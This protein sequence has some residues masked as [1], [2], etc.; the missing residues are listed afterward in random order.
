MK[1]KNILIL[2]SAVAFVVAAVTVVIVFRKQIA[3]FLMSARA[4]LQKPAQP[5]F[6]A[7]ERESFADI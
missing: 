3:D 1:K 5:D 6:T 7:E 2:I 4:R